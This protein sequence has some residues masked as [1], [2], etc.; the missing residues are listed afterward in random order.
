MKYICQTCNR[1]NEAKPCLV[2]SGRKK[3]CSLECRNKAYSERMMGNKFNDG[4]DLIGASN[5]NWKSSG[6]S[7]VGIHAWVVRR[8]GRPMECSE[9]GTTEYHRYEWANISREYKRDLNDWVR[10]CV[11]C[12]RRYDAGSLELTCV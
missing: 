10:L 7:Y 8:Q 4:R 3:F 9:C 2:K 1:E 12:H 11:S 6:I 5:P